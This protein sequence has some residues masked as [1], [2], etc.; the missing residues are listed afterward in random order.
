MI[1]FKR[2]CLEQRLLFCWLAPGLSIA[3][4]SCSKSRPN[5]NSEAISLH[6]SHRDVMNDDE[7]REFISYFL[8]LHLFFCFVPVIGPPQPAF[9]RCHGCAARALGYSLRE[10]IS[11][12]DPSFSKLPSQTC[13]RLFGICSSIAKSAFLI[14]DDLHKR[15]LNSTARLEPAVILLLGAARFIHSLFQVSKTKRTFSGLAPGPNSH[16]AM[17]PPPTYSA[18]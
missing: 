6:Q 2:P 5:S 10:V 16:C 17:I 4:A 15:R 13:A 3:C 11:R 9:F 7:S 12:N 8:P 18:S 14:L 1:N